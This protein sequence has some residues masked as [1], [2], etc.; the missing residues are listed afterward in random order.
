MEFV[1]FVYKRKENV[2]CTIQFTKIT[3]TVLITKKK[4]LNIY[5]YVLDTFVGEYLSSYVNSEKMSRY[6][7]VIGCNS[8]NK[9]KI[10]LYR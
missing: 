4:C 2:Q 5:I 7:S 6:C 8:N 3:Y 9:T 1:V 10:S